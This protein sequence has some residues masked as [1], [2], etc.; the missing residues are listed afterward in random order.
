MTV[1]AAGADE[2]PVRSASRLNSLGGSIDMHPPIA[3]RTRGSPP[4]FPPEDTRR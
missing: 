4:L 3:S 1:R 2:A